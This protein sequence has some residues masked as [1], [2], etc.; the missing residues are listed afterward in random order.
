[1][2]PKVCHALRMRQIAASAAD[3]LPRAQLGALTWTFALRCLHA[4]R[5]RSAK[6]M[7]PLQTC[8]ASTTAPVAARA[9]WPRPESPAPKPD[10]SP[11]THDSPSA[12]TADH[13]EAG[14]SV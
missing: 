6:P 8:P 5:W 13:P 4:R 14:R 10:A 11:E 3:R 9:L 2:G 7:I 12:K 1:S